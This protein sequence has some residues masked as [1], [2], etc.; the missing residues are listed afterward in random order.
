MHHKSKTTRLISYVSAS[1][2]AIYY[3]ASIFN[4]GELNF[5]LYTAAAWYS[6][7]G[8]MLARN[9]NTSGYYKF[10]VI[11]GVVNIIIGLAMFISLASDSGF[12]ILKVITGLLAFV[13]T[14]SRRES[15]TNE[16]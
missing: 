7:Y 4:V 14:F 13:V 16:A 5:L 11:M 15:L 9:S 6:I 8:I 2:L 3:V 1:L 10:F 12:L